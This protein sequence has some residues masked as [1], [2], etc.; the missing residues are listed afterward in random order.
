MTLPTAIK[1]IV[2]I[3]KKHVNL[4][5]QKLNDIQ[6]DHSYKTYTTYQKWISFHNRCTF[7]KVGFYLQG[8]TDLIEHF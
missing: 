6:H 3:F 4:E 1:R 5:P 2:K 7:I 8:I